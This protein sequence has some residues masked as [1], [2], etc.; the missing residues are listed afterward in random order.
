MLN[1]GIIQMQ[2]VPLKWEENI[3]TAEAL[4]AKAVKEGAQLVVLPEMFNVG[5][6]F[7]EKLMAVA[8]T[9]EGRTVQWL[10]D[11][12]ARHE[13]FITCSFYERHEGYFYNTMVMV[14]NDGTVQYY[15]KR[16]PTWQ[17]RLVWRRADDPGPGIFD[18]PHGRIG[19]VICFDSFSRETFLGFEQ[20]RV[21]LVIIIACW[22]QP[23]VT[24]F[25]P[26]LALGRSILKR[27]SYRAGE[28]VPHAYATKLN[29]PVAFVNNA[30]TTSSPASFP[31]PHYWPF[32]E[33]VYEFY[34]RSNIRDA[35]GE[36]ILRAGETE[37]SFYAVM[38]VE[39]AVRE[40]LPE[41]KRKEVP[42]GYMSRNYYFV[43][44]PFMAKLFQK[45][46][47]EGFAADYEERCRRAAKIP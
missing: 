20:S 39:P 29:V 19:G 35:S 46:C 30:G 4:L 24:S 25:R 22:G 6:Y 7:G 17:E 45:W 37:T 33:I 44:P 38:P 3:A 34:G 16:N 36:V 2:P 11:Q 5:F 23:K 13:C 15:R 32:E 47:Y 1:L 14:G 8:E 40:L 21:A 31:P 43:Q 18:T 9:L 41:P 28:V 42:L 26:D 27:W 12:A 10:R